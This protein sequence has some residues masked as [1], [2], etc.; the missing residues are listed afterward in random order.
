MTTV[1]D[2]SA[3]VGPLR[4][5]AAP[6]DH[7][8]SWVPNRAMISAKFKELRKRRGLMITLVVVNIGI[9]T[10]FLL[11][12]LLTH[13]FAPKTYG[14][15]GG[16]DVYTGLVAGVMYT[17]GFI[18]AAT[19]GATAGSAD[20]TEGM[21][22][23][24]VI[25]GRSRTALYLAR[26]PAGL[27]IVAPLVAIGFAVVCAVCVFAAPT[28]FEYDGVHVPVG[29]SRAG[30]EAFA[31]HH[32][33]EVINNFA[34]DFSPANPPVSPSCVGGGPGGGVIIQ[35][36]GGA[37]GQSAPQPA[38]PCT[39]SELRAQA[40]QIARQNYTDYSGQFL[41]PPTSLMVRTGLWLELEAVI[42]LVVGL[43]LASLMGQRTVPVI[44][45]IVLEIILTP[46]FSVHVIAH[47]INLERAVV[48]LAMAHIEPGGLPLPFSG[49]PGM[50]QLVPEPRFVS[51]IVIV[52]WLVGWTVLGA[53]R[54][55]TRDA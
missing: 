34:I 12:R 52:A 17:F 43:G 40:V 50:R 41:F 5:L 33:Q 21:F 3:P 6:P 26:I 47:L 20:L 49:G 27:A 53:W 44:L 42:G 25:T 54:M 10:I 35:K 18:V 4:N 1:T 28:S 19:L 9:P 2:T 32:P 22:R 7:R 16:Y 15:A 51:V 23:H 31:S 55:T 8:G 13:A 29:L 37:V 46:I 38:S 45:M 11:V 30:L 24:H 39:P 14:P 48:G 36:S